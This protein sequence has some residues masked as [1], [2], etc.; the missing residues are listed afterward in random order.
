MLETILFGPVWFL[1][2]HALY[3]NANEWPRV[4]SLCSEHVNQ[5]GTNCFCPAQPG[6]WCGERN[7]KFTTDDSYF[8]SETILTRIYKVQMYTFY[9]IYFAML[10]RVHRVPHWCSGQ[11][12]CK[13]LTEPT[14][15][16]DRKPSHYPHSE[17]ERTCSYLMPLFFCEISLEVFFTLLHR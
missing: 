2:H 17:A 12:Q 1:K 9:Y 11:G 5:T 15:V 14:P 8:I 6:A 13:N 10:G 4:E 7:Q 3:V 16:S